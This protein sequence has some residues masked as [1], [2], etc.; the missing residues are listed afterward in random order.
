MT[1]G[2]KAYKFFT[3]L[4]FDAKLPAGVSAM[5]P[6][7][8]K[9]V[10]EILRAYFDCFFA[11]ERQRVFVIGINPGRFGA[12]VTGIAFTDPAALEKYCALP[13]KWDKKTESSSRFIYQFI[14]QWGGVG[15]FTKNFFLT[16][17]CPLGFLK[18]GINYNFYDDPVLQKDVTPFIA[19]TMKKQLAFGA[20][21]DVVI[22]LGTGKLKKYVEELNARHGFFKKVIA[23][24]HPRFI[25]QY[26]QKRLKEYLAKYQKTFEAAL[27]NE[28]K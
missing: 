1:F 27:K 25:M 16:A 20:R 22:V 14:E 24:E 3:S 23:V 12:G 28:G 13:N 10:R 15:K 17:T 6:Y 8:D 4:N 21:R 5:N 26:R 7:K 19:A 9:H 11:D 2:D 18:D